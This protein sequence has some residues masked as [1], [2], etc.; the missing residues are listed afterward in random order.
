MNN[1][2]HS[3]VPHDRPPEISLYMV[4]LL[5]QTLV[6][7]VDLRSQ[8]RQ[9]CWNV[10]GNDFALLHPLFATLVTEL[11]G[12]TD[13]VAERIVVLGG[14]V[15]GTARTAALQSRLPEYPDALV[16][17]TD[18]VRALAERFAQYATA[19]RDDITLA[20]DVEDAGSAALYTDLSRRVDKQIWIL[21]AHL[22]H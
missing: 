3:P 18:H 20:T 12:Y 17:G 22:H 15:R 21:E 16:D 9:A 6:C 10:K 8:V 5:N 14:V 11:A 1:T 2:N 13:M 7:T 19:L 4:Q